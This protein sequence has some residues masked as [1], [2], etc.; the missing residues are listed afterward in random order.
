M[1]TVFRA[2]LLAFYIGC[3][4]TSSISETAEVVEPTGTESVAPEWEAPVRDLLAENQIVIVGEMHGNEEGPQSLWQTA[5]L[6]LEQHGAVSI[7]LETPEGDTEILQAWMASDGLAE[8]G[9]A[10]LQ[11]WLWHPEMFDG[12]GTQAA[13]RMLEDARRTRHSGADLEVF[14]FVRP[15]GHDPGDQNPHEQRMADV[16]T[17]HAQARPERKV[18]IL[19]GNVHAMIRPIALP[20]MQALK[21]M[22]MRVRA[23]IPDTVTIRLAYSGG[24]SWNRVGDEGPSLNEFRDQQVSSAFE[25]LEDDDYDARWPVG[26]ATPSLPA[27]PDVVLPD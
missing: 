11:A 17:E 1:K 12:R 23:V 27:H 9:E 10:L 25:L 8:D 3:G 5:I 14:A 13:M 22:A 21:P 15:G 6:A 19:V 18:V 2:T 7:G 24:Q 20:E 26:D 16:V 4:A